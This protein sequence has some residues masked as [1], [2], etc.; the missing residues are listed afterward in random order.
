MTPAFLA[1]LLASAAPAAAAP[2]VSCDLAANL[3]D[4][5][6]AGTNVR[7]GPGREHPSVGLL[8]RDRTDSVRITAAT[9]NWLRIATAS[10]EEGEI[11]FRTAGWVYAPLLG[12]GIAFNPDDRGRA[13]AQILHAAPNENS[14]SL[15]RLPAGTQVS[16]EGC[17]GRWAKIR[18]GGR[19]GWLAP[20][21]QCT[22]TRT[23]CS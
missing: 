1:L 4:P 10:D 5:D 13:G 21:G 20:A 8:P 18:H 23:E 12:L 9:G 22:N 19:I 17:A 15:A 16:L 2:E 11:F 7:R 3:I 6:P 14:R